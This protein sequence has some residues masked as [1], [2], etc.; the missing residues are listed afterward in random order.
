[1]VEILQVLAHLVEHVL[2]RD[3][4]LLHDPL[5]DVSYYLL[6]HLELLE[7]FATGLQDILG[8]NVLFAVDPEVGES[9]LSGVEY[10][11]QVAQGA[12]LVEYLIGLRELLTVL[13]G[14][15]DG[16]E[17]L[18]ESLDLVQE[19]LAGTLTVL[20]VQVIFLVRALLQVVTHHD[21][22]LEKQE[23]RASPEFLY[24]RKRPGWSCRGTDG[25]QF[26]ELELVFLTRVLA[27]FQIFAVNFTKL[28]PKIRNCFFSYGTK[29]KSKSYLAMTEKYKYRKSFI[30][31]YLH[32]NQQRLKSCGF[33]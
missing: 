23:V 33:D 17:P 28:Y 18:A 11:R 32:T 3:V 29:T 2:H 4:D 12:L 25:Y 19:T 30:E 1:V 15:A 7:Q 16:L 31:L 10:L 20:R 24:L 13:P 8:E 21:G 14:G 22:V 9:F 6:D 26:W 5:I 27:V